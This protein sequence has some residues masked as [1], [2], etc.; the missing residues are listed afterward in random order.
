MMLWCYEVYGK[1]QFPIE[2]NRN[3]Q[4]RDV[5]GDI[6]M[7]PEKKNFINHKGYL[8]ILSGKKLYIFLDVFSKIC[9]LLY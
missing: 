4:V 7:L 8:E 3:Y 1:H 5:N 9:Q 2:P 6:E